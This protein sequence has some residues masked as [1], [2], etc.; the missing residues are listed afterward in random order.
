MDDENATTQVENIAKQIEQEH[1][2]SSDDDI[3]GELDLNKEW[4]NYIFSDDDDDIA[5]V[6]HLSEGDDEIIEVRL[7]KN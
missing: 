3:G 4:V 2:C 6:D 7:R 5:S 1:G